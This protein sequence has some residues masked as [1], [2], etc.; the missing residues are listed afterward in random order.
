[1]FAGSGEHLAVAMRERKVIHYGRVT[2]E[3]AG[4]V[5]VVRPD[6]KQLAINGAHQND[7]VGHQ[8]YAGHGRIDVG[9][10]HG[11]QQWT[12]GRCQS[13]AVRLATRATAAV[14]GLLLYQ[15]DDAVP[16]SYQHSAVRDQVQRRDAFA[17]QFHGSGGRG[18]TL[19][20]ASRRVLGKAPDQCRCVGGSHHGRVGR[21]IQ[22]DFHHITRA[23]SAVSVLVQP[24]DNGAQNLAL[25]LGER[26][27]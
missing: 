6:H 23:G 15:L 18:A 11:H 21:E 4:D 19:I 9:R 2:R 27:V 25:D 16:G 3:Q 22:F 7:A 1:M 5:E 17:I 14:A 20:F 24:V 13:G 10:F 8:L 26:T 12:G